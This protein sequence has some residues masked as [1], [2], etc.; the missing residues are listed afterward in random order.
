MANN[1]N[2]QPVRSV[3]EARE[4]GKKG[5]HKSGEARRKRKNLK[6][7]LLLLLS[8]EN[9]Q[10]KISLA[11]IT[12]A[13][14]GNVKAFIAIRD[15]IGEAPVSKKEITGADGMPVIQKVFVTQEEIDEVDRHINSVI[16]Q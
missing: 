15:T 12:Q 8:T 2:L 6:E 9:L 4:K 7:E 16:G 11:L 13:M 3:S 5:G 14:K 10:E 1:E